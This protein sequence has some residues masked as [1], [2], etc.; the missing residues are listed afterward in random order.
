MNEEK[1]S[2]SPSKAESPPDEAEDE[3]KRGPNLTL[4]YGLIV[5]AMIVAI[6][7]AAF[8][9]LPFYKHR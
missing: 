9:V 8:V 1:R 3:P 4:V 6:V 5:L 2:I 7:I